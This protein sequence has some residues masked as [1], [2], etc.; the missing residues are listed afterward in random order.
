M[1]ANGGPP[2]HGQTM[3]PEVFMNP[4]L[5]FTVHVSDAEKD[6]ENTVKDD[7]LVYS[8][9]DKILEVKRL[10]TQEETQASW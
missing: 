8:R 7:A 4:E 10:S 5:V 3:S 2:K 9:I 6:A 1:R